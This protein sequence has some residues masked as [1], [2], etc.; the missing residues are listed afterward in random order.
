MR[1]KTKVSLGYLYFGMRGVKSPMGGA[2]RANQGLGE[3]A[4]RISQQGN[5]AQC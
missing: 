1:T 4:L 2:N 3:Q 5:A